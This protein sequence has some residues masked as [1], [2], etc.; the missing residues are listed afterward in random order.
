M[1]DLSWRILNQSFG[2][3]KKLFN[4]KAPGKLSWPNKYVVN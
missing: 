4:G 3:K 2:K 1:H